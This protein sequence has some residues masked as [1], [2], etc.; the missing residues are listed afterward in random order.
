MYVYVTY[1]F[2]ADYKAFQQEH[3]QLFQHQ[4]TAPPKKKS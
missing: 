1:S 2:T 4:K 3:K